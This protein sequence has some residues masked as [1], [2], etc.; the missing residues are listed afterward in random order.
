MKSSSEEYAVLGQLSDSQIE[1]VDAYIKDNPGTWASNNIA[2]KLGLTK[3]YV[4]A[5]IEARLLSGSKN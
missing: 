2:C 1:A 4:D 3:S 5:Y